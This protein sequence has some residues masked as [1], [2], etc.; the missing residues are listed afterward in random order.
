MIISIKPPRI[1]SKTYPPLM[2][3]EIKKKEL[4]YNCLNVLESLIKLNIMQK[5]IH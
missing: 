1:R 2:L 5:I 3:V 4:I